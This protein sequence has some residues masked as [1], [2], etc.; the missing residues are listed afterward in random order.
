MQ[1]NVAC[2]YVLVNVYLNHDAITN[3]GQRLT[4]L[5]SA[6]A[7]DCEMVVYVFE[8]TKLQLQHSQRH[9]MLHSDNSRLQKTIQIVLP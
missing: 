1:H 9:E 5:G 8:S 7:N 4:L 2:K 6:L 3:G